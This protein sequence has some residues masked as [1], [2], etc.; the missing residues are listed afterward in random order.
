VPNERSLHRVP[1]PRLGGV[2]IVLG[3]GITLASANGFLPLLGQRDVVAWLVGASVIATL[4]FVDDIWPLPSLARLLVQVAVAAGVV[5]EALRAGSVEVAAGLRVPIGAD[6]ALAPAVIFVVGVTNIFNFMDGMDGLAATQTV[7]AGIALATAASF[8]GQG[9][10]ALIGAVL[11]AAAWGFYVHN[12]P[13]ATLFLGD[14][15]STFLGFSFSTF[16]LL[17]ATRSSPVPFSVVPLAL[18][19]F[20][21]DGTFTIV[22]RLRHGER[23][24]RAHR[25]HLYQRAV[26]TGLT[27]RDVLTVYSVWCGVAGVAA[28]LVATQGLAMTLAAGLGMVVGLGLVWRWVVR[29]EGAANRTSE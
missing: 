3:V 20:L 10:V 13:P 14:A 4:G 6:I 23:I 29:R 15:G 27:H 12:S 17:G 1:V 28:L 18:S 16:A 5:H 8:A 19:P 9:D 25:T 2:A 22:R 7:S 26:A 11:A 24:W 21:L